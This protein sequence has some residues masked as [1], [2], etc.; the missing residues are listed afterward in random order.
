MLCGARHVAEDA[1]QEGFTRT[2]E[3]WDRI[4]GEPWA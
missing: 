4:G 2:L 3:G 1:T